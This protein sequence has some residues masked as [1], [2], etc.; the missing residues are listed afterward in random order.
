MFEE[1]LEKIGEAFERLSEKFFQ[2]KQPRTNLYSP[3]IRYI[4][5]R[6]QTLLYY[7]VDKIA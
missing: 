3:L 7:S 2:R 6:K 1:C 4:L 5:K